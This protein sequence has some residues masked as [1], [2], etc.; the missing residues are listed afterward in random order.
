[1]PAHLEHEEEIIFPYIR[2]IAH[3]YESKESYAGLLCV[4]FVNP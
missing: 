4:P 3:A 1:M 2:Q